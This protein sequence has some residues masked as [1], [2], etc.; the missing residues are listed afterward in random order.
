MEKSFAENISAL[1]ETRIQVS[2][3]ALNGFWAEEVTFSYLGREYVVKT[4]ARSV[5]EIKVF[6]VKKRLIVIQKILKNVTELLQ[7]LKSEIY[8]EQC[9]FN[10]ELRVLQNA[11][12][13]A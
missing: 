3:E 2:L 12:R 10:Y 13:I 1:F 7:L 5:C 9:R 11:W 6:D 4:S 8:S